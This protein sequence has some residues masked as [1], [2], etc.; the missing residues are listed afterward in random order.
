MTN[1]KYRSRYRIQTARAKW[2][3]YN[4]GIYFI[5][6][7]T[8]DRHYYFGRIENYK[9]H[10]ITAPVNGDPEMKLSHI[11]NFTENIFR[12]VTQHHPYAEIPLFVVMPNHI[13]AII[14]IDDPDLNH[15]LND[16]LPDCRDVACHVSG[17]EETEDTTCHVH[18]EKMNEIRIKKGLLS[19]VIGNIKSSVT[20]YAN[21]N[22]LHFAW[23]TR[24]HDRIIR[25]TNELNM[26]AEYI[27][28]NI[29]KWAYDKLNDDNC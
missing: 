29:C 15:T 26:Y 27:E 13:H 14:F 20:R 11:G 19:N 5:T 7:C 17:N 1:D 25:N 21:Q 28:N 23:Q 18:T 10:D 24:F 22:G 12:N 2:Y 8:A 9:R 6:I 3:D 16:G 4:G